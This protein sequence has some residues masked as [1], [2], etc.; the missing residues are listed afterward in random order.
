MSLRLIV[1]LAVLSGGLLPA[2][3]KSVPGLRIPAGFTATEFSGPQLANDVFA[4]HVDS[5][6]RVVVCGRGYTRELI[7]RDGDGRADLSRDLVAG[8]KDGPMG[9]LWEGD[10]LYLVADGGLKRYRGVDGAR[11]PTDTETILAVKTGGEHDAHAVRRGPDG[12]LYLLCGNMAGVTAK[13]ITGT[14]SP[15][16]API[17]GSLVRISPDGKQVEVVADGFRNAYDFDFHTSGEAFTYDSDN[18]RCV[19]LPWYEP[20]RFYHVIP[21]GNHG[22]MSP[23]HAQTWRRPPYFADVTPPVCT[24]GRGSPTGVVCY[25]HTHFPEKYRGG[26]FL[27]DWTFGKVWFVPLTRTGSGFT[28][29][30]EVFLEATGEDGFAPTGLAV[31]PTTGELF[32]SVGGRGTRGAVY[33]ISHPARKGQGESIP[34]EAR[35]EPVTARPTEPMTLDAALAVLTSDASPSARLNAVRSVQLALGDLTARSAIG[36]VFEGYTLRKPPSKATTLRV[37]NAMRSLFPS[38]HRNLDRELSRTLAAL[39][40]ADLATARRVTDRLTNESDPLDDIH[41]L[42]VL[43]RLPTVLTRDEQD[44]VATILLNLGRKIVADGHTRDRHWPLRI[45]E[46]T[47]ALIHTT[48]G[49]AAAILRS[50]EFG[51]PEHALFAKLDG[52]DRAAAAGRFLRVSRDVSF[53]WTPEVVELLAALTDDEVRPVLAR[54]WERG[55]LADALVPLYA[56]NPSGA[57]RQKFL[58]GLR[59]AHTG[60]VVAAARAL[61]RLPAADGTELVAALTALRRIG[62]GKQ[63][64]STRDALVA[65]LRARTGQSLNEAKDWET[66][67]IRERPDLAKQLTPTGYD[68]TAWRKRLAGIDWSAGVSTAGRQSFAKAQ[69]AACHDGSQSVGPPL[70]GVA[71][72]FGRDDLLTA[73]LDPNRDVPP[74]YRPIRFAT[75]DGKTYDGIVIY[76]AVDGVILQTGPD[77]TVRIAGD[78]IESRRPLTTSLMPAGLLDTLTD[79]EVADLFAYLKSL[80]DKPTPR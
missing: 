17:A 23:Q 43:A 58:T 38:G 53:D 37:S 31:H 1:L 72:R 39:G 27:A 41:Y 46:A 69:C 45:A 57:D 35:A 65:L 25:R 34:L 59:S 8:L 48:P 74:R 4:L 77:A 12:W 63:E 21:G 47:S 55:D 11:P 50:P 67:L 16:K 14:R 78:R 68:P 19:G 29:K 30:P 10:T 64:T 9:V 49:L 36:G 73:I 5:V 75:T 6:G 71:K 32:V 7:D 44:R 70:Q 66:W 20:T 54:L 80:D 40:D 61:A 60:T 79:R 26:F 42:I 28:G 51:R 76:E 56:S 3:D 2:A 62:D 22:W 15:V 24:I 33:R 13:H 18:E 52:M